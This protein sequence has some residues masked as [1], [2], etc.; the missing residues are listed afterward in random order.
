MVATSIIIQLIALATHTVGK[1]AANFGVETLLIQSLS[2]EPILGRRHQFRTSLSLHLSS[3]KFCRRFLPSV[4]I[5]RYNLF[6]LFIAIIMQ[7]ALC[8]SWY[9]SGLRSSRM[10]RGMSWQLGTE[11]SGQHIGP[12]FRCL[13][14]TPRTDY[15]TTPRNNPKSKG[16]NYTTVE[17][18]RPARK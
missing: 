3:I 5:L 12:I 1:E 14:G 2:L 10:L 8:K 4:S 15:Q 18:R 9:F 11:I 6:F 16:L 7:C 13:Y 17:A